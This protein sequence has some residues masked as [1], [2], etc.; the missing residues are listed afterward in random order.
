MAQ[1]AVPRVTVGLHP[2]EAAVV[3]ALAFAPVPRY[4]A[5]YSAGPSIACQVPTSSFLPAPSLSLFPVLPTLLPALSHISAS[6]S[7]GEGG[8]FKE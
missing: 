8:H 2:G 1:I 4:P 3:V 5:R 7:K 6:G